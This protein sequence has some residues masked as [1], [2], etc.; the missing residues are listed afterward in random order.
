MEIKSGPTRERQ[1]RMS[2]FF[3]MCV[4]FAGWFGYDGKWGYPAKNLEWAREAMP[5]EA[6]DF[7]AD[8]KMMA[9][10]LK[11]LSEGM[12]VEQ[13]TDLLGEPVFVQPKELKFTGPELEAIVRL[14][15]QGKVISVKTE[16]LN[17]N[18]R[19]E[20]PNLLARAD[21]IARVEKGMPENKLLLELGKPSKVQERQL[22]FVG[23]ATY[24]RIEIVDGAAKAIEYR[25]NDKKTEGDIAWQKRLAV[26]LLFV[27]LWVAAKLYSVIRTRATLD[28]TGLTMNGKH[29]AWEAMTAL[30]N[31]KY[32][33]KGWLDLVYEV[34]G[35]SGELRLDSYHIARFSEIVQA[36]CERKEFTSPLAK[37]DPEAES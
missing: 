1:I 27:A 32:E 4:V 5:G 17:S 12:T 29:I 30:K 20:R 18:N 13:L 14:D 23:L 37:P 15:D 33:L 22:W 21:R 2:V 24:A 7:Q 36:I 31:D 9:N 8:P 34:N 35:T 28:D 11:Q 25:E 26:L 6:P 19:P 10:N 3:L 16:E